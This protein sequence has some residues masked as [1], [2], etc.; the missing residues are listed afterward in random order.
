MKYEFKPSFDKSLKNLPTDTK[1]EIRE[2]CLIFLDEVAS[3]NRLPKGTG[4]KN[5]R[6]DFWEIR[7]GLKLRVLFRWQGDLIEFVLAGSHDD[8]KKSIKNG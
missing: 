7:K 1:E 5:L 4:L 3:G 8:I 6:K 2:L